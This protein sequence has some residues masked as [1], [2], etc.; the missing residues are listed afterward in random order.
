MHELAAA[1]D[2]EHAARQ[3]IARDFR[4]D[5]LADQCE[6]LG[7][8]ADVFRLGARQRVGGLRRERSDE[9]AEKHECNDSPRGAHGPSLP[10]GA[11]LREDN[12]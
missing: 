10:V 2:R 11:L 4:L 1:R 6:P 9:S 12:A 5:D 3:L 8:H 7:R